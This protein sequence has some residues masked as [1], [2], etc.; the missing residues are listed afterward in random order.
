LPS[1]GADDRQRRRSAIVPSG[2]INATALAEFIV[3]LIVFAVMLLTL[4]PW[5]DAAQFRDRA[6]YN[7]T[8]ADAPDYKQLPRSPAYAEVK[9]KP[10]TEVPADVS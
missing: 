8:L 7:F 4:F 2:R 3:G 10:S 6:N 5:L 1:L 9:A